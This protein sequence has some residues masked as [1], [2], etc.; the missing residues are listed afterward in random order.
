MAGDEMWLR[1]YRRNIL[2]ATGDGNISYINSV[3]EAADD[4]TFSMEEETIARRQ[5]QSLLDI[6]SSV[7]LRSRETSFSN[8]HNAPW[9]ISAT[10][11]LCLVESSSS[12]SNTDRERQLSADIINDQLRTSR[13]AN[14]LLLKAIWD[15]NW[16]NL[17]WAFDKGANPNATCY[18]SKVNAAQIAAWKSEKALKLLLQHKVDRNRR[19]DLGR[20]PL[21]FAA[22]AGNLDS[23]VLLTNSSEDECINPTR[24][25][26]TNDTNN[27]NDVNTIPMDWYDDHTHN[28]PNDEL[29]P[30][31]KGW[32]PLHAASS[33]VQLEAVNHLLSVDPDTMKCDETECTPLDVIASSWEP[34]DF[35][36]D[37]FT[38][39]VAA[40][41]Q[42][43]GTFASSQELRNKYNSP[44]HTA[45]KMKSP[46]MLLM[47]LENGAQVDCIDDSGDTILHVC[48]INK[49]ENC[50]KV[51]ADSNHIE[52]SLLTKVINKKNNKGENVLH[53]AMKINWLPGVHLAIK[54]ISDIISQTND[55]N[56]AIHLVAE[57]GDI[58]IL[59]TIL[60][61]DDVSKG[62]NYRNKK[63]ETAFCRAVFQ[64]HSS[65]AERL[66]KAGAD[67]LIPCK[68][69]VTAIHICAKYGYIDILKFL[70]NTGRFKEMLNWQTSME[71]EG[72]TPIH[73]A[74]S[75]NHPD[76]VQLL[77]T[78]G[79]NIF[80][81]SN[82]G[83]Y[84]ACTPLH[85]A[86]VKNNIEVITILIKEDRR[87]MK[88]VDKFGWTPLHTASFF[89]SRES[90][91]ILL[92]EGADIAACT[93]VSKST[94]IEFIINNLSMPTEFLEDIFDHFII[95]NDTNVKSPNCLITIDYRIISPDKSL[96]QSKAIKAL[97]ATGNRYNQRRLL[98]HPLVESFVYFKWKSVL[99]LFYIIVGLY[100]LFVLSLN[101]YIVFIFSCRDINKKLNLTDTN[102]INKTDVTSWLRGSVWKYVIYVTASVLA[103]HEFL[104]LKFKWSYFLQFEIS[105]TF[106]TIILA[107]SLPSFL[108][109]STNAS[110]W[111]RYLAT[112]V[113]LLSWLQMLL[114]VSKFPQWGFYVQMFGKVSTIVIKVLLTFSF[115]VIGFS[116]SFMIQFHS[117]GSFS[118]PWIAFIKTMVM[119]MSEFDYDDLFKD[120]PN[121][122]HTEVNRILFTMFL[123][124]GGIVLMNLLVGLAVN[125][126]QSLE[127]HGH[128]R[129]IEKQVEFL[130]SLDTIMENP[131]VK[132]IFPKNSLYLRNKILG[133][134]ML[135]PGN[136]NWGSY[137]SISR[138]LRNAIFHKIQSKHLNNSVIDEEVIKS[139]LE[140]IHNIDRDVVAK[141]E[142]MNAKIYDIATKMKS[143]EDNLIR[144]NEKL[145]GR[146]EFS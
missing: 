43:G 99:P 14:G 44:L 103:V 19:D 31:Q 107:L 27:K 61:F 74:A 130:A 102:Y 20:T 126:L 132:Y 81:K 72:F 122:A 121:N 101:I 90:M 60:S 93:S 6:L 89:G 39:L 120:Q 53:T 94:A 63:G 79:A 50:L 110:D 113:L 100:S 66:F 7:S 23:M 131:I 51:L 46:E 10:Q 112:A 40:L 41:I 78:A 123:I 64:G 136:P 124:F 77:I 141:V 119:L 4:I 83:S 30:I 65:C 24:Q 71:H 85:E 104:C 18:Q 133:G 144:L 9:S 17:T 56:T 87:T 34:S 68:G 108:E 86:V 98:L 37:R 1:K 47:L 45:L 69:N 13:E 91:S 15:N 32:T 57:I 117:E 35:D 8:L 134:A 54:L 21:H 48:V 115:I 33:N 12:E 25:A 16:S 118:G 114:I 138:K 2:H 67:P 55:G 62:L 28:C 52:P 137:K 109:D 146:K 29:P 76:C 73:F 3:K 127:M 80:A 11:E 111:S 92:K 38:D 96:G 139:K 42:S 59:E 75:Y 49:L 22:W 5:L 143:F 129:R 125:D 142:H 82:F 36:V 58:D 88:E 135:T 145:D 26:Y 106:M 128:I 95:S 84:A 140:E 116:L 70:L 105:V 97:L